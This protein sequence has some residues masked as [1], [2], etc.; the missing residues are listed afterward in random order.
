M[1][2]PECNHVLKETDNAGAIGIFKCVRCGETIVGGAQAVEKYR[3]ASGFSFLTTSK[4]PKLTVLVLLFTGLLTGL[5]FVIPGLLPALQ[6]TPATISSHEWWRLITPFFIERGGWKEITFNL[7]SLAIVGA[8][9]ERL[10]GCRRWLMFYLLGGFVGECAGLA[11][12]PDGAGSSVAACGLLGALSAWMLFRIKT[13]QARFGAMFIII[14]ALVLTA[15]R[16]LHGPPLLAG[17]CA[18]SLILWRE[19]PRQKPELI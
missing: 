8:I 5:Q 16:D 9:A 1:N 18:A 12:K 19:A 6:R 15:I 11:W 17:I 3:K 7:V 10:W 2:K 4:T 14:G 13:W